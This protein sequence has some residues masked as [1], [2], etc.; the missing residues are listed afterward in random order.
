MF[1]NKIVSVDGRFQRSV[2]INSDIGDL[3]FFQGYKAP[4]SSEKLL[5]E[6]SEHVSETSHGSFTWTG[7][8]GSGK[9]SLVVACSALLSEDKNI[10]SAAE[11]C[12][13]N[14]LS[15][16]IVKNLAPNFGI[17]RIFSSVGRPSQAETI[18]AQSANIDANKD[19]LTQKLVELAN[20]KQQED[21]GIILFIDEMGKFLEAASRDDGDVYFFQELAEAANRSRGRLI[22]I[23]I[24]HQAF[25]E[26]S[27]K[28]SLESK[29][30]WVKIEGRFIDL[31][32]NVSGEEQIE[33]I[34]RA[35]QNG[36]EKNKPRQVKII[37]NEICNRRPSTSQVIFKTLENSWPLHA[38]T[39]ALLGPI[40][41]RRFGQNQRSIFGF[42]NSAEPSG[43]RDFLSQSHKNES[44]TPQQLWDYLK[45]NLETAIFNSPDGHRWAIA[46]NAVERCAAE[47]DNQKLVSLAKAVAIFD[48]FKSHSG[49]FPTVE[50]LNTLNIFESKTELNKAIKSLEQKSII[51]FR[52][53]EASYAIFAGSDF[54][55]E[56]AIEEEINNVTAED[57]QRLVSFQPIMAK[58]HF[59]TTGTMRW[60]EI[61]VLSKE[62]K[63]DDAD[64][65]SISDDTVGI[66]IITSGNETDG[67]VIAKQY[68][69][70]V[71]R[72][73][74][75]VGLANTR[76]EVYS[77]AREYVALTSIQ[78]NDAR[79]LGDEVGRK[80]VSERISFLLTSLNTEKEKMLID[81]NWHTEKR[82]YGKRNLKQINE[83]AS[84]ICD[85]RFFAAPT[86]KN[87]LLNRKRPSSNARDAQN[88]LI[89]KLFQNPLGE[90]LGIIGFPAERGLFESIIVNSGLFLEGKGIQDPRGAET[91]PSNL[92]PLWKATDDLLKKNTSRPV[93]LKEIF[94]LW[95]KQP[96]GV[97]AGL[98]SLLA[99]LYFITSK[100]NVLLYLDKVFQTELFE[101]DA[102]LL[103]ANPNGF[104]FRWM[105]IGEEEK[106]FLGQLAN[107]A[108]S[109]QDNLPLDDLVPLDVG[110]ALIAAFDNFHPITTRTLNL[111][112][113]ARS[114]RDL[115][116]NANDPNELIFTDL[117][118]FTEGNESKDVLENLFEDLSSYYPNKLQ[119]IRNLLRTNLRIHSFS[120][121]SIREIQ[122][123]AENIRDVSGDFKMKAFINRICHFEGTDENI[124]SIC[125][126]ATG[127]P[128]TM[129]Y[130]QDVDDAKLEISKLCRE[131]I[132]L[133]GYS[134]IKNRKSKRDVF[135][136]I[137]SNNLDGSVIK[138]EFSILDS[139]KKKVDEITS[140]LINKI[141]EKNIDDINVILAALSS[142]SA[143]Y[144]N[145][146][147]EENDDGRGEQQ[148]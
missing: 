24:L 73:E 75:I 126:L 44:Y 39:C 26:Y 27:G 84:E 100:S 3:D 58:R 63:V 11:N 16:D 133:E 109:L 30:E 144:I 43:F 76:S 62:S 36:G 121:E 71:K 31:S 1:L 148:N 120:D 17:R 47:F 94:E 132:E 81:A 59:H 98:H 55:V 119:E 18:I 103:S 114:L 113:K 22:I 91:D 19:Y 96:F 138:G 45:K 74:V 49:I 86:I 108:K 82:D 41:R 117:K 5:Y 29:R 8:Y 124:E 78:K 95:S 7:P 137:N 85:R 145:K 136:V 38:A 131:F 110:R 72:C 89:R 135:A 146:L 77:I 35:I 118:G 127:K 147:E 141:E 88:K 40:S 61:K 37:A 105:E 83:L 2:N 129:W 51:V 53:F 13:S 123:R 42:L 10:K 80:E 34:G 65:F 56:K 102:E 140:D 14:G 130:D 50:V 115:M 23:G 128:T 52:R 116:V 107:L 15:K 4:S 66:F 111:N 68:S 70:T 9:S 21:D 79:L 142:L 54:D 122:A 48:L 6:M 101:E 60:F 104:S 46:N 97:N 33:V 28:L 57:V 99:I 106:A 32:L 69:K 93:E 92:G 12:F 125:S 20:E 112:Q 25:N 143:R 67:K 87:E 139:D 90:N 134:S 64:V